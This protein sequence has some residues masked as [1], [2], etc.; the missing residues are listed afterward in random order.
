MSSH[1]EAPA[2]SKDPV[3]DN[4]DVYAYVSPDR[5]DTVT[6]IANF[7][8]LEAPPGGPNFFVFGDDVLYEIHISN[9]RTGQADISYQFK[10]TTNVQDENTFLYNTGPISSLTDPHYN[11]R[12]SY[13]VSK[14]TG[15]GA[16][17]TLA[18]NLPVPPCNIGPHSTP[19]YVALADAAITKLPSGETVFAGQRAEGFFVDLGAVFDLLDLRPFQNLHT[20]PLAMAAGI[21]T[22]QGLN[23]NTIAIQVPKTMLTAD[24]SNPTDP[25]SAKSVIGVYASASRQKS[26]IYNST[27]GTTNSGPY[28]QISRLGNPLLN[29]VLIPIGKKD[30]FNSQS[31]SAD[32]QFAAMVEMP[33][34]AKLLPVLYPGVFP[35][36]A[37]L[38][39]PRKDLVAI[40]LTGLPPG[41][42]PGFQNNTGTTMA[43]MLHL[44]M[45]IPPTVNPNAG[46]LLAGDPAGFPNGRRPVDDVVTIE[47]RAIAGLTYPL[48]D[49]SYTPDAAVPKITDGATMTNVAFLKTFPFLG[50][51]ND[52]FD[53]LP[54]PPNTGTGTASA[55]ALSGGAATGAGGTAGG[56]DT[57]LL[58]GGGATLAAAAVAAAA[59][60]HQHTKRSRDE[61]AA[62][63]PPP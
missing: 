55:S 58:I 57:D 35:H 27:G 33:E 53:S 12:Q 51:P 62:A 41:V 50:T 26:R 36:L 43:D 19:N 56:R 31:P 15:S 14:V 30:F 32:S 8:P 54:S 17:Q 1:R 42:V 28:V 13:S 45:A 61:P 7:V 39:A 23:V 10:F 46:G 63:T 59:G 4:T 11:R 44:N 6:L 25:A 40:L 29:E 20:G 16:P 22:L 37:T 9:K 47:L 3:A 5:P 24:G 48:I 49:K 34:I 18:S 60:S 2:I 52:G 21:D 38:G